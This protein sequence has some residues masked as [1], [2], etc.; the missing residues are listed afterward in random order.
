MI[1][2]AKL[3]QTIV[4]S[5]IIGLLYLQIQNRTGPSA[6]QDRAGVLF[7]LAINNVFSAAIG[8]LSVFAVEKMVNFLIICIIVI[9]ICKRTWC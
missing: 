8:M 9:G 4:I 5:L 1:L 6:S 7:F 2:R 3:G